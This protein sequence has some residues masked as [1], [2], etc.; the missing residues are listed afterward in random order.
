MKNLKYL[1][2]VFIFQLSCTHNSSS[3]LSLEEIRAVEVAEKYIL[4]HGFTSKGHPEKLPV[5]YVDV[6]DPVF[7]ENQIVT[8]RF[9]TLQDKATGLVNKKSVIYIL[10]SRVNEPN[11]FG[12]VAVSN[13]VT[14]LLHSTPI[15]ENSN[16]K[17]L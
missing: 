11:D 15:P 10:F 8:K 1:L 16:W 9:N 7:T 12:V 13:S 4:R 17:R 6:L 5:E 3:E 14:K 2:V